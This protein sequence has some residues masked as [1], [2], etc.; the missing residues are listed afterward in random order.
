[1]HTAEVVDA[2]VVPKIGTPDYERIC[3]SPIERQ[4]LTIRM[5]M[6][7]MTRLT[8]GFSKNQCIQQEMGESENAYEAVVG[9]L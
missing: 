8:N 6:R 9:V 7:R 2:V 5:A 3:T 1:M 4:N